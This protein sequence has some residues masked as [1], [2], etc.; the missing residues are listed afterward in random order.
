MY[1]FPSTLVVVFFTSLYF[2]SLEQA[3]R[4]KREE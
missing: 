4:Y 1:L 3:Q 2:C